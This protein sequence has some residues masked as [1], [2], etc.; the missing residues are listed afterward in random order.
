MKGV[1]LMEKIK[2]I[3]YDYTQTKEYSS[4]TDEF[5]SD[6]M[7]FEAFDFITERLNKADQKE[8][9]E[10][11]SNSWT[12]RELFGFMLGFRHAVLIM[13]DCINIAPSKAKKV[14]DVA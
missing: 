13:S 11:Y 7:M 14:G 2:E 4:L 8:F 10:K 6:E 1:F 3:F 12:D 5:K 9:N